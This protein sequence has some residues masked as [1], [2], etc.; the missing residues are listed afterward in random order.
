MRK[1]A[2]SQHIIDSMCGI[3]HRITVLPYKDIGVSNAY[4]CA[5]IHKDVMSY[6]QERPPVS[7]SPITAVQKRQAIVDVVRDKHEKTV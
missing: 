2:G 7:A 5:S 1:F 3:Q 6:V 4:P